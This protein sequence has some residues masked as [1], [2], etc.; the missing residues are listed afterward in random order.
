MRV[1]TK[2][3]RELRKEIEET[4]RDDDRELANELRGH[5]LRVQIIVTERWIAK[6]GTVLKKD[7]ANREKFF[8]DCVF[9]SLGL[10]DS[11]IWE[12]NLKKVDN[13]DFETTSIEISKL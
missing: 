12:I 9:Q 6:K 4:I 8:V 7:I 11:N 2:E 5:K 10:E 13:P 1:I 3:A